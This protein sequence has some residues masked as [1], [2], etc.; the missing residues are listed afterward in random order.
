MK[1]SIFLP[2]GWTMSLEALGVQ[3]TLMGLP[4]ATDLTPL[5]RFAQ[6]FMA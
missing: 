1:Y 6:E 5:Y 4:S 3:E 2:N